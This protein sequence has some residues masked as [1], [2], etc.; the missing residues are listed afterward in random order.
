MKAVKKEQ[1]EKAAKERTTAEALKA[2]TTEA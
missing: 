1:K 2:V